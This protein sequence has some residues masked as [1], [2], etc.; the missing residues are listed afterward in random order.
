[1]TIKE[2]EQRSGLER[3]TIR[4]YEKEDFIHPIRM[5]NNYRDYSEDDLDLLLRIKLLRSLHVPLGD[6]KDLQDGTSNLNQ[7][8]SKQMMTLK[9]ESF[10]L[11]RAKKICEMIQK[12]NVTFSTLQPQKYFNYTPE[13]TPTPQVQESPVL[14]FQQYHFQ[15]SLIHHLQK[16]HLPQ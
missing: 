11:D 3:A 8:L 14:S 15:S 1:M 7:I 2:L 12:D 16:V 5:E 10:E 13:E 9:D 6:I 4:F